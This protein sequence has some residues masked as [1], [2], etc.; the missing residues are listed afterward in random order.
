VGNVTKQATAGDKV[1]GELDV[2][3]KESKPGKLAI[4]IADK[5]DKGTVSLTKGT[6]F[7]Y[8]ADDG[9]SGAD[10]F[11]YQARDSF[12]SSSEG[13]VTVKIESDAD[14][15]GGGALGGLTVL[16]LLAVALG[17]CRRRRATAVGPPAT[18]ASV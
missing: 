1:T 13:E 9:A 10:A 4:E 16:T 15:G 14:G 3:D 11:R 12:S 5:P 18:P 8:K 6:Q 17:A 7:V 2:S